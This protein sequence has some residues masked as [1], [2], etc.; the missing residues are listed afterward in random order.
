MDVY[1]D[2]YNVAD[3]GH[4]L[5]AVTPELTGANT[6]P[7]AGMYRPGVEVDSLGKVF[8]EEYEGEY[9]FWWDIDGDGT[10]ELWP[11]GVGSSS[12]TAKN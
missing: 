2:D 11:I 9:Y 5:G 7:T 12:A 6:Y 1:L 4:Y 3:Q 10:A 8:V